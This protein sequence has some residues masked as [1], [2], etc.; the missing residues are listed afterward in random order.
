VG[1]RERREV[2]SATGRDR[3]TLLT[4][5]WA[6]S[7]GK[8][9]KKKIFL[10]KKVGGQ[11]GG[12]KKKKK[13]KRKGREHPLYLPCLAQADPAAKKKRKKKKEKQFRFW[14]KNIPK[15]RQKKEGRN[16][17]FLPNDKKKRKTCRPCDGCYKKKKRGNVGTRLGDLSMQRGPDNEGKG[18]KK[19]SWDSREEKEKCALRALY[20]K[21]GKKGGL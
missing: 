9:G 1:G 2:D 15:K 17:A 4:F 7:S 20:R 13:E 3:G 21:G 12:E 18:R 16:T 5:P 19:V 14:S 11:G 8:R 10:C 6:V